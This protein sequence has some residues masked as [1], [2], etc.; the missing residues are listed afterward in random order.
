MSTRIPGNKIALLLAV[1]SSL[2]IG[3]GVYYVKTIR[4]EFL[5][6]QLK[7]AGFSQFLTNLSAVLT[8][9]YFFTSI[10]AHAS[11]SS[12]IF[13]AKNNYILPVVISLEFIV[14]AVYWSLK[15][16]FTHLIVMVDTVPIA[17]D[18]PLHI[19]PFVALVLD[20]FLFN[21]QFTIPSMVALILCAILTAGYWYWLE[22]LIDIE[23]GQLYPYPFLNIEH[24]KRVGIFVFIG[25]LAFVG[26]AV[27]R[28]LYDV[29]IGE[30]SIEDN[31]GKEKKD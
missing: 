21:P 12:A 13:H 4:A 20:Y 25:L 15:I 10:V 2:I 7:E 30:K 24:N 6:D 16:F 14:T 27:L 22:Y 8:L 31:E 23:K 5:P 28:L 18:F 29:I 19:T 1:T 26:F 3:Y 11:G 17:V 9:V